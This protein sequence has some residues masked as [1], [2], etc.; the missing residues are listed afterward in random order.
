[1]KTGKAITRTDMVTL[2]GLSK[3]KDR[4]LIVGEVVGFE[5]GGLDVGTEVG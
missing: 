3:A 1:M 4:T 2:K 5:E